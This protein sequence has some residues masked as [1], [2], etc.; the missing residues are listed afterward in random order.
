MNWARVDFTWANIEPTQGNFVWT[1]YDTIVSAANAAG[2]KLLAIL[3]YSN[4]W[5]NGGQS[6][7]VP[8]TDVST[9]TNY[10]AQ[11][12]ARYSPMGV[13][14]YE[15]WNEPNNGAYFTAQTYTDLTVATYNAVKAV[16]STITVIA[17]PSGGQSVA[18]DQ[19]N[20]LQDMYA[21]G[22]GGH[23]DALTSHPY[24]FP[25]GYEWLNLPALH[26]I[27]VDNGDGAKKI[28]ITEYGQP[29]FGG[30]GQSYATEAAQAAELSVVINRVKQLS[31]VS[32]FLVYQ[33]QDSQ[34]YTDPSP[35][36]E[37]YF[38]IVRS[39]GTYKPSFQAVRNA[40][41]GIYL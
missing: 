8:P 38:G 13:T 14:N 18:S 31:Y 37:G 9:F 41:N 29:T 25:S 4:G 32:K 28:W 34:A 35:D 17:G 36:R 10:A 19:L 40:I 27:M 1:A 15:I 23:F 26:Q 33:Y 30:S 6:T 5:A 39:D 2:I 22:A 7:K 21:A 12:V 16:D 11:V 24:G 20:F 3:D